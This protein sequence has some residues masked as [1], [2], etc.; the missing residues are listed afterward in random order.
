MGGK[1]RTNGVGYVLYGVCNRVEKG[2]VL[3]R[4]P[5]LVCVYYPNK[6]NTDM[7]LAEG[8]TVPMVAFICIN[9]AIDNLAFSLSTWEITEGMYGV[10]SRYTK[11]EVRIE[12]G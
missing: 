3:D 2:L 12:K 9:L 5:A 8:A 6:G 1:K 4:L 11:Y 7:S 10:G